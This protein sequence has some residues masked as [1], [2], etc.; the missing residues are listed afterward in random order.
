MIMY[1]DKKLTPTKLAKALIADKGIIALDYWTEDTQ[2]EI[3]DITAKEQAAIQAALNRQYERLIT[4]F[5][6]DSCG[7]KVWFTPP[8][9]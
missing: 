2:L 6:I 4:F 5:G 8:S 7:N 9:V 3:D 1:M